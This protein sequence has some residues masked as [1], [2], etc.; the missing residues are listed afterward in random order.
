MRTVT[1][2]D[3]G[4]GDVSTDLVDIANDTNTGAVVS[5][6]APADVTGTVIRPTHRIT[7]AID[8]TAI[9]ITSDPTQRRNEAPWPTDPESDVIVIALPS[10]KA[11]RE[12]V[13]PS[14]LPTNEHLTPH[15]AGDQLRHV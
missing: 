11:P 1:V 4:P 12:S 6:T 14:R 7:T 15:A 3:A 9:L 2:I 10:V 13:L 5:D 8:A